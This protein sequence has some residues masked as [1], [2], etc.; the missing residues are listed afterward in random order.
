MN[1]VFQSCDSRVV[2]R[3]R[4]S[5]IVEQWVFEALITVTFSAVNIYDVL[6]GLTRR[7]AA[8]IF[9]FLIDPP[10]GLALAI[11]QSEDCRDAH[12][13]RGAL[14]ELHALVLRFLAAA[15]EVPGVPETAVHP[16]KNEEAGE[17]EV[18]RKPFELK[19]KEY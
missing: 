15:F 3:K 16:H 4:G 13:R 5:E 18:D 11:L 19:F 10:D 9:S 8:S 17:F 14:P 2:G 7:R 1:L 12:F 6:Q